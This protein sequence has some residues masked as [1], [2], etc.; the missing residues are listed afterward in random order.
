MKKSGRESDSSLTTSIVATL[1]N[2]IFLN[3]FLL[4]SAKSFFS[5]V[6]CIYIH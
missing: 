6:L 1:S 2:Y 5:F 3:N 4:F